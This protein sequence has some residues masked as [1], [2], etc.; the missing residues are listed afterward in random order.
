MGG[1][2]GIRFVP[3]NL[4]GGGAAPDAL[5]R[6]LLTGAVLRGRI[7]ADGALLNL[8]VGNQ[9]LPLPK[10]VALSPGTIVEA[11][12]THEQGT[13]HLRLQVLEATPQATVARST[14]TGPQM[15]PS[16][17]QVTVP[18]S[19]VGLVKP[20]VAAALLPNAA[21]IP[22]KAMEALLSV[23]V[24][25]PEL[26]R[27]LARLLPMLD[28]RMSEAP[29]PAE[30]SAGLRASGQ[31]MEPATPDEFRRAIDLA[32][33]VLGARGEPPVMRAQGESAAPRS[34]LDDLVTLRDQLTARAATAEG[35]ELVRTIDT[36]LERFAGT[37]LQ[38]VRAFD[39]PYQFFAIP[40][41]PRTG[42]EHA[43]V[44]VLGRGGRG[45]GGGGDREAHLVVIDLQLTQLGTM[46]ITIQ[47][48]GTACTC[49]IRT[50]NGAAR[51][52]IDDGAPL[53]EAGL[54]RAGFAAAHVHT[55]RWD[56]DR[57]GAA[58]ALFAQTAAFEAEA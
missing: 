48:A 7:A 17:P 16:L 31:A 39:A 46:W 21:F 10:G 14:A 2:D 9:T 24:A 26:G 29:L 1:I 18:P 6:L 57:A 15:P 23:L 44:H 49:V 33:E 19:L 45:P 38:N 40:L 20:E 37:T 5:T 12:V 3:L 52:A 22:P 50:S 13:P 8:V 55:E 28:A 27:V 32:R 51:G 58:A 4:A 54:R 43:Q 47:S 42:I 56:G 36:V 53:L 35:R 41:S 34:L 11:R 25:R 30:Q